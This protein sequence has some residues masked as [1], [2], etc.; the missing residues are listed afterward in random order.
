MA[1][2]TREMKSNDRR[3]EFIQAA[4]E[5]FNEKG[6]ENTSVDDIVGKVGVAK[7]LFYYYFD[8]KDN[9]LEELVVRFVDETR[10]NV[11]EIMATEGLSALEKLAR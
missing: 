2:M 10:K 4:E 3:N 5:L 11:Q 9:L 1:N 6:Y 8:T 7:G